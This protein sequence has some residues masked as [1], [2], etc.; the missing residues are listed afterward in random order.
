MSTDFPFWDFVKHNRDQIAIGLGNRY[1]GRRGRLEIGYRPQGRLRQAAYWKKVLAELIRKK[2][3]PRD[4]LEA[5]CRWGGHAPWPA[6]LLAPWWRRYAKRVNDQ[7]VLRER[8]YL[9]TD[10]DTLA[11]HLFIA[12]HVPE[13]IIADCISTKVLIS[14]VIKWIAVL[15]LTKRDDTKLRADVLWH[16]LSPTAHVAA[17]G[18]FQKQMQGLVPENLRVPDVPRE[19]DFAW[20]LYERFLTLAKGDISRIDQMLVRWRLD[21]ESRAIINNLAAERIKLNPPRLTVYNALPPQMECPAPSGDP[22]PVQ[23]DKGADDEA[24]QV[25][26]AFAAMAAARKRMALK[27]SP[28][29]TTSPEP[30]QPLP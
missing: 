20:H 18:A 6:A 2:I 28:A 1:L 8:L 10:L 25:K 30:P 15:M 5:A 23:A 29:P 22:S 9:K 7:D 11:N 21:D 12:N 26:K 4:A 17:W 16:L 13:R 14:P 3:N 27:H 24:A 19:K